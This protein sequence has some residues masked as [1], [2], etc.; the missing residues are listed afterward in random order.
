MSIS[1][2]AQECDFRI[3]EAGD[4][5]DISRDGSGFTGLEDGI[6][7]SVVAVGGGGQTGVVNSGKREGDVSTTVR[8]HRSYGSMLFRAHGRKC[9]F[10]HYPKGRATGNPEV[11]YT[12]FISRNIPFPGGGLITIAL[13][14]T[15]SAEPVVGV[16]R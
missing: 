2:E 15:T 12:G 14:M 9:Q 13:T 6:A 10:R 16:A 3:G 1:G 7:G 4:W 5:I 11:I 8:Y